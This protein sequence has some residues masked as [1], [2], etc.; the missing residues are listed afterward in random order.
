MPDFV[1]TDGTR[2]L[3]AHPG[4]TL[5]PFENHYHRKPLPACE[6]GERE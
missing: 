2:T 1:L 5:Q 4:I 3:F 6:R